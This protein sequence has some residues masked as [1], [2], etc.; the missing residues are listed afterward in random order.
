MGQ[1]NGKESLVFVSPP[2]EC[3]FF[4]IEEKSVFGAC[5]CYLGK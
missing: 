3:I 5:W 4:F 2:A 1:I